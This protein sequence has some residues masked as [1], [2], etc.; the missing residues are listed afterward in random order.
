M[1]TIP[2]P[3]PPSSLMLP[4][5]PAQLPGTGLWYPPPDPS[6][7]KQTQLALRRAF[8]QIYQISGTL[9][10]VGVQATGQ[11]TVVVPAAPNA[12][13]AVTACKVV[14]PRAGLWLVTGVLSFQVLDA[15]DLNH[16]IY[17][18]LLIGG[19]QQQPG[20]SIVAARQQAQA[21]LLVQAQP[22]THTIAQTWSFRANANGNAQLQVQKD[23]AATG[24]HTLV[25]GANSSI[26]A[27]WCGL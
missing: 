19:L 17:G 16:P 22:E 13:A 2:L 25:D 5:A 27:V 8:D 7:S 20:Q 4:T 14:F 15:G 3:T 26:M 9:I 10:S 11:G 24:T 18:S 12:Y 1:S 6:L 23:A 21:R